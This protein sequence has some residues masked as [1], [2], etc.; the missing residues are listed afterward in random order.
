MTAPARTAVARQE[1]GELDAEDRKTIVALMESEAARNRIAPFLPEGVDIARVA[2]SVVLQVK[3]NPDLL[4]CTGE[5]IVLA[6]AAIHSWGL[7]VGNDAYLVPFGKVCTPIAGYTG[8]ARLM[9]QSGAVRALDAFCVYEGE[10][11]RYEEGAEPQLEHRPATMASDRGK[12]IGAYVRARLPFQQYKILYMPLEEIDAIRL[13]HSKQWK[14]GPCP[15]WYAKK[16]VV[17][18]VAKLLPKSPA[19]L[20]V[21]R[22][23]ADEEV[24]EFGKV[25][26]AGA[27]VATEEDIPGNPEVPTD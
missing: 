23:I 3:R 7:E 25:L 11:F 14:Q 6:T 4:Q 26:S 15:A 21:F 2:A 5:S 18:Q 12:M 17:R 16:T 9:I 27:P 8:L 1:P 10:H 24:E 20:D 13:K 22:V 19:L